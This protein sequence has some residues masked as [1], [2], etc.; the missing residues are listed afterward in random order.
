[1]KLSESVVEGFG[2]SDKVDDL[3]N[4][5]A[6]K[7]KIISELKDSSINA[8]RS[9]TEN[10]DKSIE[11]T[12]R[13]KSI[14]KSFGEVTQEED[15]DFNDTDSETPHKR[16]AL[17]ADSSL[18]SD[19]VEDTMTLS[20]SSITEMPAKRQRTESPDLPSNCQVNRIMGG[21]CTQQRF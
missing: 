6:K 4:E 2:E 19:M 5:L 17:R 16:K 1:M 11:E 12:F 7:I 8:N 18:S 9:I 20:S 10:V 21:S 15:E 3:S 13:D 14:A